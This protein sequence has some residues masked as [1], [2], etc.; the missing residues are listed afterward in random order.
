MRQARAYPRPTEPDLQSLG[1]AIRAHMAT[2][3][4][5]SFY[6]AWNGQSVIVEA[7]DLSRVNDA[8]VQAAV[9]ACPAPSN[10]ADVKRWVDEM[11]LAEK[12][13]FLTILDG[14]NLVRSKLSPP[15]AAVTPAQFLNAIKA[16][17]DEIVPDR[18]EKP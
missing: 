8:T 2:A 12:A 9:T 5:G 13:T 3:A 7:P 16:K 10:R 18:A 17:A 15:L 6:L 4:T 11:P 1:D 14:V